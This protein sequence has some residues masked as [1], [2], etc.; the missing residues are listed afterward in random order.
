[1]DSLS[2]KMYKAVAFVKEN[3]QKE[4]KTFEEFVKN[5]QVTYITH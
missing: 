1:M 4:I 5:V 3:S 2:T